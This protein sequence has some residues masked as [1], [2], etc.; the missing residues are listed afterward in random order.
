MVVKLN[1]KKLFVILAKQKVT[2]QELAKAAGCSTTTLQRIS[3]DEEKNKPLQTVTV[4]KLAAALDVDVT[5]LL[6]DA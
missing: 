4:G 6:A 2:V 5:E 3:I 1:A